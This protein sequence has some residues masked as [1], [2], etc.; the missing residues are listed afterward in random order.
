MMHAPFRPSSLALKL[1]WLLMLAVQT[2][3][4]AQAED[5][6]QAADGGSKIH[7][8]VYQCSE[9][10]PDAYT[11]LLFSVTQLK[12]KHG[13]NI[14]IVVTCLGPGIHL[15]AKKPRRAVPDGALDSSSGAVSQ[16][17]TMLWM[18]HLPACAYILVT[19]VSEMPHTHFATV[20]DVAGAITRV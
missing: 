6:S 11:R 16:A 4:L 14:E 1:L 2:L 9:P 15:L 20:L 13:D 17:N 10:G 8:V 18:R 3:G 19:S 5:T 7:R 12:E